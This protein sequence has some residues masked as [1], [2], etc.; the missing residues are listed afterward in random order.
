MFKE[1]YYLIYTMYSK[2]KISKRKGFKGYEGQDAYWAITGL[3]L[4][5]YMT[6]FFIVDYLFTDIWHFSFLEFLFKGKGESFA[7]FLFAG[8]LAS[9]VFFY[10]YFQL[11]QKRKEIIQYYKERKMSQDRQNW[12]KFFLWL[13]VVF[14]IVSTFWV[15]VL[16]RDMKIETRI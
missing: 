11:S 1:F 4:L 9:P 10:T 3:L 5:N 6:L 15:A 16:L 12:G 13:Y 2:R 14:T 8:I 7:S